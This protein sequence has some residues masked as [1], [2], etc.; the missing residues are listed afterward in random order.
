MH[1]RITILVLIGVI[2]IAGLVFT[3][4]L[5]SRAQDDPEFTYAGEV[6]APEFPEDT[7]WINV[8]APL[9]MAELEGK[10]VL[11]DFWTYGCI[12]CIH[13]IPDLHRLEEEYGDQLVV[14][15]VHSAKFEN[16]GDT[17]NIRNIVQRY[18]VTHPVVND[19]D[20]AIWQTYGVRAWPTIVLI[21]PLG[22][23][24]GGN[25]GEGVYEVFKPVLEVMVEEYG[26]AGLLDDTPLAKLEP[27]LANRAPTPLKYPGKV[28]AD[29]ANDRIV[30]ADTS[31]HRLIVSS[32]DGGEDFT[33]IGQ[34]ERGFVDGGF[35][36]ATFD[37]PQGMAIDGDLIYL[38]DTG[39][40]A[41]RVINLA[42]ETV[43]TLVGTGEQASTYPPESGT[44]PDVALSSPWDVTLHEGVLYIA[45]AGPHQLW[46]IDLETGLT[47]AHA[48][49]G[50]ENII[51]GPLADAQ[52]AQPSG[53]DTDGELLY[54]ADAEVSA[55]RT[56]SVSQDGSVATIVGTGLFDFGDVDGVGDEVLLQHALGVTVTP[57]GLLY[58][59]DTYNNKIKVIDPASRESTTFAGTGEPGLLDGPLG[60]AQFWE[61]G[62]ID[63]AEGKLYIADT[64]NH[65]I[66][67]IDLETETV[68]TLPISQATALIPAADPSLA[69]D[70]DVTTVPLGDNLVEYELQTVAPGEGEIVF[71]ISMPE[72]YK[73]NSQAPFTVVSQS[74]D[75]VSV[76]EES[77]NFRELVPELPVRLAVTFEEGS[78][79]YTADLTIY[80]C[81]AVKEELCFIERVSVVAPVSVEPGAGA[82]QV[83]LAYE[84]VPPEIPSDFE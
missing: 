32:L 11:L 60:E 83:Q 76:P 12:N 54:F 5:P 64:N 69:G 33:V 34:G 13:V 47:E 39:N 70:G 16:E 66:R 59:A 35:D 57:D 30:I 61:P 45:M 10:I 77:Q 46:R 20:F 41:I 58:I 23:V 6:S 79:T 74:D 75:I 56:A 38:A 3:R 84:L 7:E 71:N 48:G 42:D 31:H 24:V 25:A 78:S 73:L 37:S 50:R 22:R 80:W 27:E 28:Q 43:T 49:S 53:I 17:E 29:P 2:L 62:G 36:E 63:Y 18:Q 67:I 4:G 8:S 82:N 65:A 52:L 72:G 9:T 44:A 81:E 14:I 1:R 68:S 19:A 51:D 15:G 55:I 21:D 26:A 40:H